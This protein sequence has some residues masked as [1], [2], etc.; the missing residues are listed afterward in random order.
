MRKATDPW[1]MM[2]SQVR[3]HAV[4]R[5]SKVAESGIIK[6]SQLEKERKNKEYS[7]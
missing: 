2:Y 7:D 1:G 3:W 4:A 6:D 5:F